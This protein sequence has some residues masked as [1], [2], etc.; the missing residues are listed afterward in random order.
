MP[1]SAN[2]Q[3]SFWAIV[4]RG[5]AVTSTMVIRYWFAWQRKL[6]LRLVGGLDWWFGLVVWIGGLDW[7]FGLVVWIGGLVVQ[8]GCPICLKS[9]KSEPPAPGLPAVDLHEEQTERAMR[10]HA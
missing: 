6:S 5:T 10:R 8:E 3:S 7:W 4:I 1:A 9:P 2:Y